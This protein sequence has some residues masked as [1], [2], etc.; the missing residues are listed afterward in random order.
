MHTYTRSCKLT[1]SCTATH[2]PTHPHAYVLTR[3]QDTHEVCLGC[4]LGWCIVY[5]ADNMFMDVDGS[6]AAL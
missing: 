3:A 5:S 1:H 4:G 2:I 6:E